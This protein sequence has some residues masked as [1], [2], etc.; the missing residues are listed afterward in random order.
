MEKLILKNDFYE[1]AAIV[2]DVFGVNITETLLSGETKYTVPDS[3]FEDVIESITRHEL[4]EYIN[5][6]DRFLTIKFK[7]VKRFGLK[8]SGQYIY[9][10]SKSG[11]EIIAGLTIIT[12]QDN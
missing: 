5:A 6:H 10:H 2:R 9:R 7:Y 3:Y 11:I 1:A 4:F 12:E 8:I